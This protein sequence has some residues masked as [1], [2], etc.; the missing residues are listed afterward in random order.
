MI[1]QPKLSKSLVIVFQ[2]RAT[3]RSW[4]EGAVVV[5]PSSFLVPE[6]LVCDPR[7]NDIR[8]CLRY[9]ELLG[10]REL[11]PQVRSRHKPGQQP[12]PNWENLSGLPLPISKRSLR[13][14][15]VEALSSKDD[16]LVLVIQNST[17]RLQWFHR[18]HLSDVVI[19]FSTKT[20]KGKNRSVRFCF[21]C[22]LRLQRLL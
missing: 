18:L 2:S 10:D 16:G 9:Y 12:A 11:P 19:R 4:M 6:G 1:V 17:H 8:R 13:Q 3:M 7:P 21:R 5:T 14:E 20:A 22:R 15:C